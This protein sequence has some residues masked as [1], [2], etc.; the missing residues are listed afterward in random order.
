[1]TGCTP[2]RLVI[3]SRLAQRNSTHGGRLVGEFQVLG[4]SPIGV[5][6]GDETWVPTGGPDKFSPPGKIGMDKPLF[7]RLHRIFTGDQAAGEMLVSSAVKADTTYEGTPRALHYLFRNVQQV[8]FA[9]PSPAENGSPVVYYS[10]ANLDRTL[11]LEVRLAFDD[12]DRKKYERWVDVVRDSGLLPAFAVALG[13]PLA[14]VAGQAVVTASAS[15]A[16][17]IL[18]SLDRAIDSDNDFIATHEIHI[19][20]PGLEPAN[21]GWILLRDDRKR[22]MVMYPDPEKGWFSAL[23]GPDA[24]VFYVDPGDGELHYRSDD[25]VV[26]DLDEPYVLLHVSGVASDSLKNYNIT[27]VS[28]ELMEKFFTVDGDI[29]GDIGDLMSIYNDVTMARRVGEV[30]SEL[31]KNKN[32]TKEER[33]E[34]TKKRTALL[35]HVQDAKLRELLNKT[36]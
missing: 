20:T 31:Q 14:G 35:K 24:D 21:V 11:S 23:E 4:G 3:G 15:A 16:K 13:G 33:A 2:G 1:M 9:T 30:D 36:S 29:I 22:S 7:I 25:R 8:Q 12:F 26:D 34:L 28:A 19:D 6:N 5:G 32:L 17:V 10:P 18:R 27:R